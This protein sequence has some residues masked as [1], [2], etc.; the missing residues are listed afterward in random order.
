[1][2]QMLASKIGH[3]TVSEVAEQAARA[4]LKVIGDA[5]I[6]FVREA[7]YGDCH[8]ISYIDLPDRVASLPSFSLHV[9]HR[10][11]PGEAA[12]EAHYLNVAARKGAKPT[13]KTPIEYLRVR[14]RLSGK[15][16]RTFH[17]SIITSASNT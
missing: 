2:D 5:A 10:R 3:H 9:T 16:N 15:Y 11:T 4:Q 12:A 14:V 7:G 17:P 8:I 13:R 6:Q 1:M